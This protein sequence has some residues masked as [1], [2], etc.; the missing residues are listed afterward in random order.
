MFESNF[1]YYSRDLSSIRSTPM[2]HRV[3]QFEVSRIVRYDSAYLIP[4]PKHVGTQS[5]LVTVL[6]FCTKSE[7]LKQM[8]EMT[9]MFLLWTY[10]LSYLQ[11]EIRHSSN[12]KTTVTPIN[13]MLMSWSFICRIQ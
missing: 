12:I 8:D 2:A 3:A 6:F 10:L 13:K 5:T 11:D 4:Q 7:I 9:L 1:S